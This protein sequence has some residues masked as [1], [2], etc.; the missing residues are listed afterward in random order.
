MSNASRSGCKAI[1]QRQCVGRT[2]EDWAEM[3]KSV[4]T[5]EETERVPPQLL[6]LSIEGH[7]W[8]LPSHDALQQ[9]VQGFLWPSNDS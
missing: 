3:E 5:E 2:V 4:W 9:P 6:I 1:L 8:D 7:A